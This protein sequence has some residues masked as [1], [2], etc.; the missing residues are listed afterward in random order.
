MLKDTKDLFAIDFDHWRLCEELTVFEA[1]FLQIGLEPDGSEAHDIIYRSK[2]KPPFGYQPAVMAISR[3]LEK[4]SINGRVVRELYPNEDEVPHSVN[5]HSSL[6]NVDS[7]KSW[8]SQRGVTSGFFFP[9]PPTS[10]EYLNTDHPRYAPKLAAAV[11]GWLA[12]EDESLLKAKRPKQA[13]VKW[14]NEHAHKFGL[15][16]DDGSPM[17]SPIEEIAKIANW[18]PEG[19]APRTPS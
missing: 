2:D 6:V 5:I 16:D 7:L 14:L 1:A 18:E 10:A 13:L 4:G 11:S 3:A 9:D 17:K 15:T 19:G 8:L 12:V